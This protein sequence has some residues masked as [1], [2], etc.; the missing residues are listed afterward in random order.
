MLDKYKAPSILMGYLFAFGAT[1]LWSGNFIVARG[2]SDSIPPVTL[3]FYRWFVAI[4]VFTPFALKNLI[5]E[6]PIIK[7]NITYFSITSMLVITS[8]SFRGADT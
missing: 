5:H 8:A 4:T 7:K 1:A 2:L 6:W 3:A